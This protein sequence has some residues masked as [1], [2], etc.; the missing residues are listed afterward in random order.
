MVEENSEFESTKFC[1]R[2]G[3]KVDIK[4]YKCP[5]CGYS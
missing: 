2:C 5:K 1:V 3:A 4:V